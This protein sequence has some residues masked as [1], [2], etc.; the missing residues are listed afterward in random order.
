VA[1]TNQE[2]VGKATGRLRQGLA[3]LVARDFKAAHQAQADSDTLRYVRYL[4][5][6]RNPM[7]TPGAAGVAGSARCL[8]T[9]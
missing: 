3:P 4:R 5:Y 6:G 1:I 2:R 8:T 9:D 7:G